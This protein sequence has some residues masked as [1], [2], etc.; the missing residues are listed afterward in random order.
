MNDPNKNELAARLDGRGGHMCRRHW[1]FVSASALLVLD[2][3]FMKLSPT[4]GQFSIDT[5][6]VLLLR[7][8]LTSVLIAACKYS[9]SSSILLLICLCQCPP[10]RRRRRSA[11]YQ[12]TGRK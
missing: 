4:V 1:R 9:P 12:A 10:C 5:D 8:I 3:E 6:I 11:G 7:R 2:A